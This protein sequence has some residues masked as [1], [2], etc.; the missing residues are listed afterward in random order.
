MR[1]ATK[2]DQQGLLQQVYRRVGDENRINRSERK[3]CEGT[4]G[5]RGSKPDGFRWV[6]IDQD[7][8]KAQTEVGEATG[9]KREQMEL[10]I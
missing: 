10:S 7:S 4:A 2:H 5:I 9:E 3:S 1:T 6:Q 8:P